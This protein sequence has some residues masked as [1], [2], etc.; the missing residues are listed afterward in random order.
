M[1][2]FPKHL[3]TKLDYLHVRDKFPQNQWLPHF[4]AL[5]DTRFAWLP[6]EPF[7]TEDATHR[8]LRED[9]MVTYEE[10]RE[11]PNALIFRLGFAAAEVEALMS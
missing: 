6:G 11:D 8:I 2:D 4:Q 5:L 1:R 10:Y 9:E 7:E 3:N